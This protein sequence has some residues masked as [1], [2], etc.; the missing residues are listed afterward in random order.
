M[1]QL[2]STYIDIE[3][4]NSLGIKQ[5]INEM[6][7]DNKFSSKGLNLLENDNPNMKAL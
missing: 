2:E 6:L 5:F 1:T 7:S 3:Q 4:K